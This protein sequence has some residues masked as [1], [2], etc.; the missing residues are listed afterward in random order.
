ML[1]VNGLFFIISFSSN[2]SI[3]STDLLISGYNFLS[4]SKGVDFW[5]KVFLGLGNN[6]G[7]LNRSSIFFFLIFISLSFPFLKCFSC[8]KRSFF[9]FNILF[10]CVLFKCYVPSLLLYI[11]VLFKCSISDS[12]LYFSKRRLSCWI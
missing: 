11:C 1:F 12:F 8:F 2:L 6:T 7:F 10:F 3:S 9:V 4:P 5:W